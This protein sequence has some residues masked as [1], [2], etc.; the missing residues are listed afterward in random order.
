MLQFREMA[1]GHVIQTLFKRTLD[2]W[3]DS[4]PV[5]GSR[6]SDRFFQIEVYTCLECLIN[7]HQ[8]WF[9]APSAMARMSRVRLVGRFEASEWR[10]TRSDADA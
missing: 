4:Q 3:H 8:V 9:F 6:N 7:R 1:H 5:G 2:V 10:H